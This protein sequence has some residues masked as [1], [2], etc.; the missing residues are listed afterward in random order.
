MEEREK[1]TTGLLATVAN[2]DEDEA[3]PEVRFTPPRRKFNHIEVAQPG[4]FLD[5]EKQGRQLRVKVTDRPSVGY[6]GWV[7][8][9]EN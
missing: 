3:P 4:L 5:S 6:V 9:R 1:D 7:Q 2:M 8:R